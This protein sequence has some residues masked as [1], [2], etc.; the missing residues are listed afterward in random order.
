MF[1]IVELVGSPPN[2]E[3][4]PFTETEDGKPLVFETGREAADRANWLTHHVYRE[5]VTWYGDKIPGR[6]FQ[7]RPISNDAWREREA[8]RFADGTYRPLPWVALPWFDGSDAALNHYAH[9][10]TERDGY[11]AFTEDAVKGAADRQTRMLPGRY[12]TRYFV[13]VLTGDQIRDLAA[14]FGAECGDGGDVKFATTEDEFERVYVNGPHSCMAH[15]ASSFHGHMHPVRVYVAGD[16][17]LAYLERDGDIT[18]RCLVWPE[19]KV[20]GRVYGDEERL[21]YHLENLGYSEGSLDRA[22]VQKVRNRKGSGFIMPYID[23][24]FRVTDEGDEKFFRIDQRGEIECTETNGLTEGGWVCPRCDEAADSDYSSYVYDRH[25]S[26]CSDCV[27]EN[28]FHC[29][30]YGETYSHDAG[31]VILHDGTVWSDNYFAGH[32]A[33]CEATDAHYRDDETVILHDGTVWSKDH[34]AEH[35]RT[36]AAT[37]DLYRAEEGRVC[38]DGEWRFWEEADA[39]EAEVALA[40]AEGFPMPVTYVHGRDEHPDQLEMA[41]PEPVKAEAG[42]EVVEFKV[43]ELTATEVAEFERLALDAVGPQYLT[44]PE[45]REAMNAEAYRAMSLA[46]F[47]TATGRLIWPALDVGYPTH[48]VITG[49]IHDSVIIDIEAVSISP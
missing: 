19:R 26:W 43:P 2:V 31:P 9:P 36:C 4:K 21:T 10:S 11:V 27:D 6:R 25:E 42:P 39:F 17:Q 22:R 15:P 33:T 7:P 16:L 44:L 49:R 28:T 34:F 45:L 29:E 35:G 23:G 12:L 8:G 46:S 38:S 18:A 13:D 20:Y 30:G 37:G 48:G 14:R 32:G 47:R 24:S 3:F 5:R 40:E 1:Q 41:L